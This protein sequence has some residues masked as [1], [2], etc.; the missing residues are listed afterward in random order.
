MVNQNGCVPFKAASGS[1]SF[2]NIIDDNGNAVITGVSTKE[3]MSISVSPN[4][5]NG[6]FRIEASGMKEYRVFDAMGR[7]VLTN[8]NA[9]NNKVMDLGGE[10]AGIYMLQVNSE[11]DHVIQRLVKQ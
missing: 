10:P 5:S 1:S 3:E 7:L 4:P 6:L 2:S 9:A 11:K 8:T